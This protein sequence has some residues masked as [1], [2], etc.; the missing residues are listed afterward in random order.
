MTTRAVARADPA[1]HVGRMKHLVMLVGFLA[2]VVGA[3][4]ADAAA[5][6][7]QVA[8]AIK[9]PQI[10]VVHLWA[11]WC[12]NCNAELANH[13]WSSFV[14]ANPD[15]NFIFMT[16]WRAPNGA[17]GRSLLKK[18]G[19][20]TQKN[21]TMLVHPNPS[22]TAGERL[23]TFLGLPV[24]WLPATWIFR[25]GKLRYALNY[26]EL[27]FP[28]LQQMIRDSSD[29]WSRPGGPPQPGDPVPVD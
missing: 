9:S 13:G 10:T 1:R 28:M 18:S 2:V 15:V 20:G 7:R 11:P 17:D 14:E 23:E 3:R 16:T 4:A 27:R 25:E 24:S 26:G 8:E 29:K 22:F 12:P 5:I 19:L 21:F 6:E